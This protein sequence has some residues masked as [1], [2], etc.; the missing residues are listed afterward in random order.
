VFSTLPGERV[1][2]DEIV[3][4]TTLVVIASVELVAAGTVD[5]GGIVAVV[6]VSVAVD[7]MAAEVAEAAAPVVVMEVVPDESPDVE[8]LAVYRSVGGMVTDSVLVIV[9]KTTVVV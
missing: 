1:S 9:W 3:V 2:V 7:W 4:V 8:P 5:V 6:V